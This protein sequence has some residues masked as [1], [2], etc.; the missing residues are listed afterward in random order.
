MGTG[1]QWLSPLIDQ[2]PRMVVGVDNRQSAW[3]ALQ[4]QVSSS[5]LSYRFVTIAGTTVDAGSLPCAPS[6]SG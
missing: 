3:G 6:G 4:L 5:G 2:D 1:G